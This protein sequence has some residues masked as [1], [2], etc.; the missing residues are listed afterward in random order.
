MDASFNAVACASIASGLT[1][2]TNTVNNTD[3]TVLDFTNPASFNGLTFAFSNPTGG[4]ETFAVGGTLNNAGLTNAG[5]TVNGQSC[6]L[7]ATCAI[8]FQHNGSSNTSQNGLNQLDSTADSVG[9]HLTVNNPS[10]IGTRLE[11]SGSSYA[12]NAATA[13]ALAATPSLCSTGQAPTGILANGNATGCS[14]GSGTVNPAS[15]FSDAYY[16]AAGS[17]TTISGVTAPT[18]NGLYSVFYNVIANAAVAPTLNLVGV[19]IDATNPPTLLYSDRASYLNW[20]SG[21]A[22]ALPAVTGNFAANMPFVIKNTSTTLTMTPNAGASDLIDGSA[23][24]TIIPNFAAFVYQ[25][26]TTA[27][28]HWFT[29]KF[30]TFAAF[31][32][33]CGSSTQALNWSTTTGFGCQTITA[34]ATA[35][36]SN[37]Q[38]QYNNSGALGGISGWTT[39]GT[40]TQV[41]GATSVLDLSA[42]APTSGLKV[43]TVA[44]AIPAADG[45]FGVNST[46]HSYVGGSNGTTLGFAVAN[47]GTGA[48]TTCGTHT[49]FNFISTNA[50]PTCTQP[51]ASDLSVAALANGIAATTQSQ[52]DNSTKI[53]TTAYTDLAVANGIAAV[54]PAAA[55]LAASTANLTGTYVQVGGGIGDTFTVTA[56]GAFSLDGI[57]INTIGQRVLLKD[58]T[59]ASQNGVYTATVV[60]TTG[61]SPVFTRALDYDTPSDVNNSGIIPVQ[62]GTANIGTTWLLTSQVTSIGSSGSSLTYAQYSVNSANVVQ[63]VSPGAGVAHFAGSTQTVTSSA[64]TPG[65]ATGNTTGSGNFVLVTSPTL[66][67]PAL[68]AA[69]ATSLLASGIVDGKAP[70]TVTTGTT[71]TLGAATYQSGYTFNQEATAGTGVT[72]TLPA[73]AKGLQYCVANSIVSGTGAPNTGVLTVYPPASSYIIY[74]GVRNTIGGGGTHGIA[75]GGAAADAACF[76]AVDATDWV[77]YAQSG[78]WTEN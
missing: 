47:T 73:T 1:V 59:T 69:T 31:G 74:K 54:N 46:N 44:G 25:D 50:V 2:K 28:G 72:Y 56:T 43:P 16:S 20:T 24:G 62:S 9:L 4:K 13:T 45:F 21:T 57:A 19:P 68:G 37:T 52:N 15:Q 39:N 18:V 53:A 34:T 26:S 70:V 6:V 10:G 63:A 17:A 23:S 7:G 71:A 11:V 51:A 35:G 41:G 32:S 36:G 78:T 67:T 33:S 77:V 29:V 64:V 14:A 22:L 42:M 66:V 55:V 8:P 12:G 40:T 30:P 3:Q 27:P 58:Q 76:V 48:S 65:D 38:I 60:G 5:T 49:W 75:S 61:V